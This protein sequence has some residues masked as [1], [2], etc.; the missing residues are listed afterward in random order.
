MS[1]INR[2][3][4]NYFHLLELGTKK[5]QTKAGHNRGSGPELRFREKTMQQLAPQIQ[6]I[7]EDA[8][9]EALN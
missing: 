2:R 6:R 3:P 1:G 9:Q 8:I 7:F 5:R 4:A